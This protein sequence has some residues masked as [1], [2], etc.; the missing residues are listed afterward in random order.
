MCIA[1]FLWKAH[2]LYPFLL[3]LNRDEFHNRP[4][5]GLHW[6]EDRE[7]VGGRDVLAGATW[8]GCTKDGRLAFLTNVRELDR[9]PH[10]KTRGDLPVRFLQ[11][12]KSPMEFAQEV[13]AEANQYN[14]FNLVLVDLS[15][16]TIFYV[17]NRPKEKNVTV[18]EVR[19]GIH[20]LSNARLDSP[21]PKALRLSQSF[22]EEL[23]MYGEGEFPIIEMVDK[24]MINSVKDEDESMLPHIYPVE[25][26]YLASSIFVSMEREGVRYGT[27]SI[28][29]VSARTD[30]KVAFYQ[31]YL[32]EETW[33]EETVSFQ[34]ETTM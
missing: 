27:T 7:I 4:S 15:S 20:V 9:L 33:N 13:A 31:R 10:P 30:G 21:W 28:S 18:E 14:G 6:W 34:L 32:E 17:T 25:W 16:K 29:A 1:V 2:P 3:L 12:R 11:S 22:K 5:K 8:L 23:D 24:L 26:E 19:P